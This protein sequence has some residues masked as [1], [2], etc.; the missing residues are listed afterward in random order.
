[1]RTLRRPTDHVEFLKSSARSL[2]PRHPGP[3]GSHCDASLLCTSWVLLSG[4][5]TATVLFSTSTRFPIE[6]NAAI[7]PRRRKTFIPP[8]LRKPLD[9]PKPLIRLRVCR[10]ACLLIDRPDL[11]LPIQSSAEQVLTRM[12]PIN[13]RDP[14]YMPGQNSHL[15]A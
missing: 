9:T 2:R 3:S 1:M 4:L 13:R 6:C 12:T 8:Y 7:R 15:L 5:T 14:R 10:N 11:H